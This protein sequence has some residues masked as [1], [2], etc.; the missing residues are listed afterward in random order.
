MRFIL[1]ILSLFSLVIYA[2]D[3]S[4]EPKA[5]KKNYGRIFGGFESNGQYYTELPESAPDQSKF[6]SNNFLLIN[7]QYEK[8]SAGVQIE[9]YE[10]NA[11][12]NYYPG[13][14][15]TDLAT[16]FVNYKN[17]SVDVT[18]GYFYEQFGSGLIL[19]AWEDRALGINSALRGAKIVYKP[20]DDLR[21]TALAG[22]QRSGF[23]VSNG[24]IFGFDLDYDL[25]NLLKFEESSLGFGSSYVGRYEKIDE[26]IV[27]PKFDPLTNA[28][29]GRLNFSHDTFT[30]IWKLIINPKMPFYQAFPS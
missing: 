19:R 18:L 24:R 20:T 28:F 8:F 22:Q 9:A 29:S 17:N 14:N 7:Y 1:I 23:K 2:Q 27:E 4:N 13:L 12:L 30:P 5:E 3:D 11:L 10:N 16:Y 15:G 26:V 25:S 21:L 6:R